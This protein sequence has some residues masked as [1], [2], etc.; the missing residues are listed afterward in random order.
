MNKA[1]L[2]MGVRHAVA[3]PGGLQCY[4]LGSTALSSSSADEPLGRELD[5]DEWRPLLAE[6][7]YADRVISRG[8]A[9]L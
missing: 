1:C 4:G 2:R 7:E 6:N 9:R 3:G 5:E 8:S